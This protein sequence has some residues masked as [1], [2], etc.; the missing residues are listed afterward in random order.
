MVVQSCGGV[1]SLAPE[2]VAAGNG[3]K[4]MEIITGK[5]REEETGIFEP[6]WWPLPSIASPVFSSLINDD[7]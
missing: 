6:V 5:K 7:D 1:G 2:V 4:K 3:Q